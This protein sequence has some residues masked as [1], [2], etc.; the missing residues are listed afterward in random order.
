MEKESE[1]MKEKDTL[2]N[3]IKIMNIEKASTTK[4]I[5]EDK[6]DITAKLNEEQYE[7]AKSYNCNDCEFKS[8]WMTNLKVHKKKCNKTKKKKK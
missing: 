1:H 2:K 8:I 5:S 7:A 4:P 6:T 3:K